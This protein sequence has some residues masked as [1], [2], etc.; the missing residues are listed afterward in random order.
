M[1][2]IDLTNKCGSCH[3]FKPV[4]GTAIGE[5]LLRPY[6]EDVVHDPNHPYQMVPRSKVKCTWHNEKPM[7]K[8][9]A[10]KIRAMSDE[11]LANYLMQFTDLDCRIGFCKNLPECDALLETEDGIPLSMCE[12]CLLKWLRQPAEVPE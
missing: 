9:N 1:K 11:W 5:C 3:H 10:D 12:K 6:G 7:T 2:S 4:D 8:T